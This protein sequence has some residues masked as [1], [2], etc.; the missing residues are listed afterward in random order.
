M[1]GTNTGL[2]HSRFLAAGRQRKGRET[3]P[4]PFNILTCV[5]RGVWLRPGAP[6]AA[7]HWQRDQPDADRFRRDA[8]VLRS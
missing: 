1:H 6:L 8:L 7:C 4:L 5:S 2:P 3:A